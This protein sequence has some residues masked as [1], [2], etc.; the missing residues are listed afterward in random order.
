MTSD[1]RSQDIAANVD[2]A[3]IG[4]RG[5]HPAGLSMEAVGR[6]MPVGEGCQMQRSRMSGIFAI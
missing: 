1:Q 4:R 3:A 5:R 6:K 2:Q